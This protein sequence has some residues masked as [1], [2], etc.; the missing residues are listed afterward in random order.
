[1]IISNMTTNEYMTYYSLQC[2]YVEIIKQYGWIILTSCINSSN[3]CSK[4]DYIHKKH[5][6]KS[7]LSE[8]E[9]FLRHCKTKIIILNNVDSKQDIQIIHDKIELFYITILAQLNALW[10]KDNIFED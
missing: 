8:I 4:E 1:M 9:S 7:Y 2:W 6:V 10:I 3:T 5:K